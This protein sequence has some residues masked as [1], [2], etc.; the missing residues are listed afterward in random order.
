M[1]VIVFRNRMRPDA[2]ETY[3]ARSAEIFGYGQAMP[4]FRSI[5][6]Y[7]AEDGERLTLIEF[8]TQEQV[9]AWGKHAEHRKAQQEGRDLY[10]SEYH[11]QI[12]EIVRE[13]H[14]ER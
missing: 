11:L 1:A 7:T 2:P 3:A 10:Y 5:K 14:W 6:S 13:S 8:D 12:C 4:G 9:R